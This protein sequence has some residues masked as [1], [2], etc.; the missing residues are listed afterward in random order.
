MECSNKRKRV[1]IV[2][3]L[4]KNHCTLPGIEKLPK[5]LDLCNYF[6]PI[7]IAW[8]K[9]MLVSNVTK[10]CW[11]RA[12]IFVP[13]KK[14]IGA[15]L[16]PML[17]RNAWLVQPFFFAQL[18]TFLKL[19]SDPYII[20][21]LTDWPTDRSAFEAASYCNLN[22]K[23]WPIFPFQYTYVTACGSFSESE[24]WAQQQICLFCNID[25]I[26]KASVNIQEC[27]ILLVQ[28]L[29]QFYKIVSVMLVQLVYHNG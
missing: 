17:P 24:E 12:T 13:I 16:L 21:M 3:N 20:N 19:A 27:H 11:I 6:C 10:N 22:F 14:S 25:C 23:C 26:E 28:T 1:E 2:A 29:F 7:K 4:T 15:Y 5:L 18:K 8:H 9:S